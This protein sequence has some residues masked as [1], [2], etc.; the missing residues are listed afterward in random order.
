[1]CRVIADRLRADA[2]SPDVN[3]PSSS[4]ETQR[5]M[6]KG[7]AVSERISAMASW[8]AP[9]ASPTPPNDPSPPKFETAAVRR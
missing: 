6:A 4:T 3:A 1:M 5:F 2:S 8:M 7:F 9:G